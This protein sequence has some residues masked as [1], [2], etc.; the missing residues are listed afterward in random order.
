MVRKVSGYIKANT[1]NEPN[2]VYVEEIN[3]EEEMLNKCSLFCRIVLKPGKR[4][5]YHAHIGDIESYFILSG[6]GTYNCEGILYPVSTGDMA[7]C[8]DGQSHDITNDGNE[9][10]EIIALIVKS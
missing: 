4:V 2:S 6:T 3:T 9:D 10:L 5:G 7:Y 1:A 8:G